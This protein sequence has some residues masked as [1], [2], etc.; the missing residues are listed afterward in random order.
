V[1]DWQRGQPTRGYLDVRSGPDLPGLRSGRNGGDNFHHVEAQAAAWLRLSGKMR[2]TLYVNKPPCS[3]KPDGCHLRIAE[4]L[5]PGA[6]LTV[7]APDG[8]ART[9]RGVR[10]LEG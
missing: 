3:T 10:D 4:Q 7:Y 5:P 6:E 2:A 8:V 9:Y 1:P